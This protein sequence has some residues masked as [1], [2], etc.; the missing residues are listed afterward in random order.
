MQRRTDTLML[1][2]YVFKTADDGERIPAELGRLFVPENRRDPTSSLIEL[3][4]VRFRSTAEGPGP[5][6]VDLAGGPGGSGIDGARRPDRFPWFMALR[7]AGDLILLD[8]RGVG[9][10]NP[11]LDNPVRRERPPEQPWERE[12]FLEESRELARRSAAFWRERGVDLIGYTTEESADDIDALRAA[13]CEDRISLW[14]GSYG[15]HLA[16]ATI[17]RHGDRVDRRT[18]RCSSSA[19]RW[20]AARRRATPKRSP[21]ASRTATT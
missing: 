10:S 12:S 1:A 13:L 3:A 16:L 17:K 18:C 7:A 11:R 21:P 9:L 2:P 14:G 8:Q 4:F 5:P 6:I 19:A 15:S 20:T